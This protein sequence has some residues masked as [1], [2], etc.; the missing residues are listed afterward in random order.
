MWTTLL[1]LFSSAQMRKYFL[2]AGIILLIFIAGA[3]SFN[4]IYNKGVKSGENIAK[5]AY[6]KQV[7]KANKDF[8]KIQAQAEADRSSL[9]SQISS[10]KDSN[11]S[12][13]AKLASENDNIQSSVNNY[14]KTNTSAAAVCIPAN[15]GG[16]RLINKSFPQ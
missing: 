5:V 12:L 14:E 1:S 4:A 16:L 6:E 3:S 8:Q 15:D 13:E 11:S 2:Y 7:D 9:N 10:L